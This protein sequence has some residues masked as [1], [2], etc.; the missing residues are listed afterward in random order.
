M[1]AAF[2]YVYAFMWCGLP[3]LG[4]TGTR[5]TRGWNI[6]AHVHSALIPRNHSRSLKAN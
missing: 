3:V 5:D 1:C 6:P 2:V 4:C